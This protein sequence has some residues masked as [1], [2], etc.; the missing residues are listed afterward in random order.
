MLLQESPTDF[1]LDFR[2][3][4]QSFGS[5]RPSIR[6]CRSLQSICIPS[7]IETI[8]EFSFSCCIHLSCLTFEP[9][10]RVSMLGASGFE[11]CSSLQSNCIHPSV[12]RSYTI[13]RCCF[14]ECKALSTFC[15]TSLRRAHRGVMASKVLSFLF[16]CACSS[17][18]SFERNQPENVSLLRNRARQVLIYNRAHTFLLRLKVDQDESVQS[19]GFSE[20]HRC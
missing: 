11:C 17:Q 19:D 3:W 13:C 20:T 4:L 16:N 14:R 18:G 6:H 5:W 2:V 12:E 7:S 10:C 15:R 8:S 1:P 9:G